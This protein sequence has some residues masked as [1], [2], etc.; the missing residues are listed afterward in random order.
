MSDSNFSLLMAFLQPV[1]IN[2]RGAAIVTDRDY[3][4]RRAEK[5]AVLAQQATHPAAVAAHY[6]LSTVYLDNAHPAKAPG[7]K[8]PDGD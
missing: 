3:F 2:C 4:A 8:R 6:R 5:E 7:D 1:Q